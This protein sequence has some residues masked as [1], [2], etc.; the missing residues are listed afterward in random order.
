[1]FAGYGELYWFQYPD[2]F[3]YVQHFGLYEHI[4][5]GWGTIQ[6]LDNGIV[7]GV[8]PAG[9][10]DSAG[11]A[12][13]DVYIVPSGSVH[14]GTYLRDPSVMVGA[15]PATVEGDDFNQFANLALPKTQ[16]GKPSRVV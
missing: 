13:A 10:S 8:C 12:F 14:D 4:T 15:A 7:P 5:I 11:R 16:H 2:N 1:A 9:I 6:Y 3:Q